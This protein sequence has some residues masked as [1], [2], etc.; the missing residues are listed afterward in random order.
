MGVKV[1]D[2]LGFGLQ[3]LAGVLFAQLLIALKNPPEDR[4]GYLGFV[5]A[6]DAV[7]LFVTSAAA[8]RRKS[9]HG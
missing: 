4:W 8:A 5:V 2:G 1:R 9:S 3:V 6:V 7:A